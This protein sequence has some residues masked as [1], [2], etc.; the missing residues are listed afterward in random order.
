MSEGG[1]MPGN[2]DQI[3]VGDTSGYMVPK[4]TAQ[5]LGTEPLDYVLTAEE[6]AEELGITDLLRPALVLEP[7]LTT[8]R[9]RRRCWCEH[10]KDQHDSRLGCLVERIDPIGYPV[11]CRCGDYQE[12][13]DV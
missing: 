11:V 12:T 3:P 6:V 9:D 2:S 1:F 7:D 5:Q 4:F 10:L 8:K 13:S